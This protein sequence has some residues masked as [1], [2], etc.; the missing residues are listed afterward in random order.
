MKSV[1]FDN[2]N[3]SQKSIQNVTDPG[4]SSLKKGGDFG[5]TSPVS[6]T[7]TAWGQV[8]IKYRVLKQGEPYK[9]LASN[10]TTKLLSKA[11]YSQL[12]EEEI[13]LG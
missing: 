2:Q 3:N 12:K 9:A 8:P 10:L 5:R 4:K 6:N 13:E 7:P 11:D 1:T